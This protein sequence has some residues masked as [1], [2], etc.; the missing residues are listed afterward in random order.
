MMINVGKQRVN[1]S[2]ADDFLRKT[3]YAIKGFF[4]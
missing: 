2:L 4:I 3:E 1:I